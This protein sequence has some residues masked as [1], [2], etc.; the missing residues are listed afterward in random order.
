MCK[1]RVC[2][3]GSNFDIFFFGGGGGDGGG[4]CLIFLIIVDAERKDPNK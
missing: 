2:Q 1:S 3:R 4:G